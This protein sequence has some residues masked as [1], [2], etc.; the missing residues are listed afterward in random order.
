MEK[1]SIDDI[2]NQNELPLVSYLECPID[3]MV[4]LN[5]LMC[6]N[7]ETIF[8]PDC[9]ESWKKRSTICP[10]RC[11]P[12][13]I[14]TIDRHVLKNQVNKIKLACPFHDSGCMAQLPPNEVSRH[15]RI[16]EYR[17]SKCDKCN[18][19]VSFSQINSH[20][21][22]S[23]IQNKI[24][25]FICS[26]SYSLK[27]LIIH[28]PS[29]SSKSSLCQTCAKKT[30]SD[31]QECPLEISQ[32]KLCKLPELNFEIKSGQHK[33]L[34]ELKESN[35]TTYLKCIH[36]KYEA[37]LNNAITNHEE[38]YR[39]FNKKFNELSSD[40]MKRENE[41]SAVIEMKY[42]RLSDDQ[43]KKLSNIKR[44]KLEYM[45]KIKAEIVELNSNIQS[46]KLILIL[47]IK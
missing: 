5:P 7:C 10:M 3:S 44:D 39:E 6:K 28:L 27:E 34:Q 21:Y 46:K 14:I 16:C 24:S 37:T 1:V 47:K 23:C 31:I 11:N 26:D 20:L 4:P 13:E 2:V 38:Y 22:E 33:C 18:Q 29:C 32:C 17:P 30:H 40:V 12:M 25:C 42:A 43:T 41:K 9:I 8:C 15:E 35:L 36:S 19:A 45:K